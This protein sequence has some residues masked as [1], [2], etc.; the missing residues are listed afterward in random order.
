MITYYVDQA[1]WIAL[2]VASPIVVV[3]MV[4][5]LVL[6]FLQAVFQIQDQALPF[7]IKLVGVVLVLFALGTWQAGMLIQFTDTMFRMVSLSTRTL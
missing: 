4:L 3:T 5:G 7:A 2:L 1:L 6:G